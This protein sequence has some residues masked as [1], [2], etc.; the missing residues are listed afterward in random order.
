MSPLARARELLR[1]RL[2]KNTAALFVVQIS[3]YAA[4]LIVLPYLSRILTKE[5]FGLIAFATAFNWYF[6]TLVDYGFNLTATRRIAIHQDEPA[7]IS[8]IFSSVMAAKATLTVIGFGL[9][10]A[11]VVAVPKLRPNLI[12]FIIMYLGVLGDLLFPLWLFQGLQKME[13]LVWR[14]LCAKF[15]SLALIFAFVRRDDQYLWAAGFQAGSMAVAGVVGLCAVPF[16]T[17][18]RWTRPSIRESLTA[19]REG[20]PVFLSV[21]AMT[22]S[23]STNTFVLGLRSGPEDVAVYSVAYRLIVAVRTLVSPAVTAIYPHMSHMAFNSR[24]NAV[25]FLRK[26]GFLLGLPFLAA[27]LVLCAGAS[28]II[29]ILFGAK[30]VSAIPLLRI[31]AFSPFLL[32]VQHT[33]STF[34]MLAFGYEKEWSRVILQTT[35]LNFVILIPLIY[36]IWPPLAVSITGI[37][38]DAFVAVATYAFYRKNTSPKRQPLAAVG[39]S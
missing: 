38:L 24:E 7:V 12:L 10:V 26:Y 39:E 25:V 20:W 6:M 35:V 4:P 3:G 29:R 2:I 13:N 23:S 33:Y 28:P 1:H 31:L 16:L 27:S 21:A 30:Y 5:H 17:P 9:M 18:V 19:F 11:V 22:L 34:Y 36:L 8:R 32:A 14:D 15:L 37:T